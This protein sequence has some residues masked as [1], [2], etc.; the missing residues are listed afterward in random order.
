MKDIVK[1]RKGNHQTMINFWKTLSNNESLSKTLLKIN[2]KSKQ[3][4][5][6]MVKKL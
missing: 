3:I 5:E 4:N 1:V 2:N 6:Q